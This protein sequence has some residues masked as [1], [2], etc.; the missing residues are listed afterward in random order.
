MAA[1][2]VAPGDET[3]PAAGIP[4]QS[5][6]HPA[7]RRG[8][9]PVWWLLVLVP[10]LI[11]AL[12]SAVI[13]LGAGKPEAFGS[14]GVYRAALNAAV[15]LRMFGMFIAVVLVWWELRTR[16]APRGVLLLAV[17]SGPAVYAVLAFINS[18]SFFPPAE[19]AYYMVNPLA[20]AALGSQVGFAALVEILWRGAGRRRGRWGGKVFSRGVLAALIG[21]FAVLYLAVLHAG[22]TTGFFLF[23]AGYRLLFT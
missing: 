3:A 20:V 18:L 1:D 16:G 4:Q 22:G 2:S 23:G 10:G 9:S 7:Q 17:V 14:V 6:D 5:V 19:A 21:G 8:R 15:L 13:A 12:A 11:V